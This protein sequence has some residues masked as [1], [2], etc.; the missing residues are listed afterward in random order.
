[1]F[2]GKTVSSRTIPLRVQEFQQPIL[3]AS[4][5]AELKPP[6]TKG[7]Y[8]W[9]YQVDARPVSYPGFTV[10]AH[11]N[12]PTVI[13]YVNDLPLPASSRLEPLLTIDQTLHWA[14]PLKRGKSYTED[15]SKGPIPTVTQFHRG[16]PPPPFHDQPH[17][18]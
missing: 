2:V 1:M 9:G 10:E 11:R 15:P 6:Y 5:Y 16:E 13:T 17:H 14:D 18:T 12:H 3:S 7:T 8:L 4:I